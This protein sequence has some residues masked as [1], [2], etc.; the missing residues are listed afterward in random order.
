[1]ENKRLLTLSFT[2]IVL[3][4]LFIIGLRIN[5]PLDQDQA[6]FPMAANSI[7]N[8]KT[9][10]LIVSPPLY[11]AILAL[12]VK[13][14]GNSEAVIR[15]PGIISFIATLSFIFFIG[16]KI[17]PNAAP[18]AIILACLLCAIHPMSLQGALIPDIDNTIMIPVILLVISA[19]ISF[20]PQRRLSWITAIGAMA[21]LFTVK[22]TTSTMF[23]VIFIA[24]LSIKPQ[25]RIT[26]RQTAIITCIG[27]AVFISAWYIV[28]QATGWNF[29]EPFRFILFRSK[30]SIVTPISDY[31]AFCK[32]IVFFLAW[33]N[34]CLAAAICAAIIK[35]DN[36][37][38]GDTIVKIF[39]LTVIAY[40]LLTPIHFGF[41][42]YYV[43][44]VSLSAILAIPY[45]NQLNIITLTR[46]N[47]FSV[48]ALIF[49]GFAFFY[50]PY[51]PIYIIRYYIRELSL[52]LPERDLTPIVIFHALKIS[53]TYALPALIIYLILIRNGIKSFKTAL[54]T[55]SLLSLSALTALQ[56]NAPYNVSHSYG[57]T[58]TA[59]AIS[60]IKSQIKEDSIVIAPSNITYYINNRKGFDPAMWHDKAKILLTMKNK[61]T[62]I[63][64]WSVAANDVETCQM[65]IYNPEINRYLRCNFIQNQIGTHTIWV[66]R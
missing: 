57:E 45:L 43:P 42:K 34:P 46:K 2:A 51:D 65:L 13:I 8:G 60:Y 50:F 39:F 20:Q 27:F 30:I 15:L 66:R 22:L 37:D 18:Q 16:R 64:A 44:M 4:A 10:S 26:A 19:L 5:S 40:I 21:L 61:N 3:T 58:M 33:F 36:A 48:A 29:S 35:P 1:M 7:I 9:M 6:I 32:N 63:V 17:Y 53:L 31:S 25:R 54:I 24:Y 55:A 11:P 47:I 12:C 49:A 14:A 41:P 23:A 28:S 62:K 59:Q 38:K 52:Y 56:T